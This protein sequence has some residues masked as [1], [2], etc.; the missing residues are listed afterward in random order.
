VSFKIKSQRTHELAYE[1]ARLTGETVTAAVTSAIEE[2]IATVRREQRAGVVK[3]L[4]EIGRDCA[5]HMK[6]PYRSM[7]YAEPLYDE[8][9][10]PR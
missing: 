7:D 2:R 1:L 4:L 9:G 6:E 8:R 5:A 3:R 10:L